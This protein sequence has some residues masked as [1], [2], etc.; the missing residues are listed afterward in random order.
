VRNGN[1][2]FRN[3]RNFAN[4]RFRNNRQFRNGR[5]NF[6][7]WN[8]GWRNDRRFNWRGFR[9]QNRRIFS[10]GRYFSPIRGFRYRRFGIG[11]F[12]GSAFFGPQFIIN[13][14]F[15]YR[16]PPAYGGLRWIRYF[17]DVLL[18]DTYTG[19]VVDVIPNFFY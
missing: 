14:P 16:L 6:Q 15:F 13:D 19:Q 18:V 7:R 3:G 11:A 2:R 9:G 12:I 1:Q 17:D 8:R 5:G 10:R 4:N